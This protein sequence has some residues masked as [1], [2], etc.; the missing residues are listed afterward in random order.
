[1][2]RGIMLVAAV[3]A[4]VVVAGLTAC[5]RGY[6]ITVDAAQDYYVY[7]CPSR[8]EAGETVVV[9]TCVVSDGDVHV[10][11]DGS[12]DFGSFTSDGVYEFVM[13]DHEVTVH[14]WVTSNGLA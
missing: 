3:L 8:A 13:P 12:A 7:K 11:V 14:V 2:K 4:I 6:A 10:A 5:S 9:E 1:M